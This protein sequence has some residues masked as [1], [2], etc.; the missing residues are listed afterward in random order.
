MFVRC[1]IIQLYLPLFTLVCTLHRPECDPSDEFPTRGGAGGLT[2]QS[3]YTPLS[4]PL[5][6]DHD[7]DDDGGGG[8]PMLRRTV[9]VVMMMVMVIMTPPLSTLFSSEDNGDPRKRRRLMYILQI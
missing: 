6:N 1:C 8:F 9:M 3:F 7:A 5:S 2:P 4:T